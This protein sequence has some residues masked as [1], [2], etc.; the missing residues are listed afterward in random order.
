MPKL[1]LLTLL[2][3]ACN[4]N[5]D[6]K[7]SSQSKYSNHVGDIEYDPEV[8]GDFKR[9]DD[10]S[11][12]YYSVNGGL[13]ILGEKPAIIKHFQENYTPIKMEGQTGF[14]TVR[15]VVNCEGQSGMFR[16]YAVDHELH[17]FSFEKEISDQI[18]SASKTLKGWTI[19]KHNGKNYDYYQYLSFEIIDG[20]IK[21][22]TP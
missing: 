5:T 1:L 6:N 18:L 16:I 7:S 2:F 19:A 13:K 22:I 10:Y 17:S 15:F 8:D 9:C 20:F 21:D 11:N 3:L 12:Q 4:S 14:L